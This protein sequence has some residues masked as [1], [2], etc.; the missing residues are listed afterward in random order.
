MTSQ[1]LNRNLYR[2][3]SA[4][5]KPLEIDQD[6]NHSRSLSPNEEGSNFYKEPDEKTTLSTQAKKSF[7]IDALLSKRIEPEN[8]MLQ[9]KV[10]QQKYLQYMQ[11]KNYIPRHEENYDQRIE[12]ST[13]NKDY[14]DHRR[15]GEDFRQGSG[16][17]RSGGSSPRS[18]SPGS[19]DGRSGSYSPPISPGVEGNMEDHDHFRRGEFLL[20]TLL[21]F[22]FTFKVILVDD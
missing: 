9:E 13:I 5:E 1:I 2:R 11:Q 20:W 12:K 7:C 4:E 10:N 14:I 3:D 22:Y 16:S 15:F 18:G 17:P 19:D 21:Y 8:Q 6:S